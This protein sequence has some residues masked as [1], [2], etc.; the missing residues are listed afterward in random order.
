V[1]KA[2]GMALTILLLFG[3]S[4]SLYA[5][6]LLTFEKAEELYRIYLE[7]HFKE[8]RKLSFLQRYRYF[9]PVVTYN[10]G[11]GGNIDKGM[12]LETSSLVYHVCYFDLY[13][14]CRSKQKKLEF[15]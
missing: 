12:K 3:T 8:M 13:M 9:L 1:K 7:E 15:L 10:I 4:I 2:M 14:V 5:I 11:F 6:Q